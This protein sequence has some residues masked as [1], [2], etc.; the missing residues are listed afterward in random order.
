MLLLHAGR[1]AS[2]LKAYQ[3]TTNLL[4]LATNPSR[5]PEFLS[6]VRTPLRR[7]R[8]Q[9]ALAPHPDHDFVEFILEGLESGFQVE[10]DYWTAEP[11]HL[12]CFHLNCFVSHYNLYG[13]FSKCAKARGYMTSVCNDLCLYEQ[14]VFPGSCHGYLEPRRVSVGSL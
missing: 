5:P 9:I 8:W 14:G 7:K 13:E 11:L 2:T 3:Y 4:A 10:F 1:Q 6:Q 12:N